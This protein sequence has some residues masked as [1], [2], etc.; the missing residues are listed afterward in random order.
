[1]ASATLHV[2]HFVR[3]PWD[4][5]GI[6]TYV[7]RISH[8]QLER[9]YEVSI[10]G[11]AAPHRSAQ[12]G[13]VPYI[14]IEDREALFH[15]FGKLEL[16]ILHLHQGT[17]LPPNPPPVIRTMH[18][19]SG[20]CPSGSRYLKR[21]KRPCDRSYTI[22]GCLWGRF[23]DRCGSARPQNIWHEFRHTSHEL[24]NADRVTTLTVSQFLKN[25]MARS[26][27]TVK[28]TQTLLSP[29][30]KVEGPF[31]PPSDETPP[32]FLF[33]GRLVPEKGVD[34]LLRALK[35]VSTSCHLDIAG[36]G[37]LDR[38]KKMVSDLGLE[39]RVTFHGWL[40]SS[41][42]S[43]LIRT[44]R[45]VV[46]PSVWH[47][48]AGLVTLEAAAHGRPVIAS[49]VGGIPEYAHEDF[50]HLVPPHDEIALARRIDELAQ[51]HDAAESMGQRGLHWAQT[52]FSMDAFL[53]RL[54]VHYDAVMG[55]STALNS[56]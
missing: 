10:L 30:P 47:E 23:V 13:D 6:Q 46:F 20:S 42:L 56:A 52:R 32:R 25:Q 35:H 24:K 54:D 48:P 21:Q 50:A 51:D 29:A 14:F 44:S 45:A 8:A 55:D 15:R 28:H 17:P 12:V 11:F 16:D 4:V 7:R 26:G 41:A 49:K 5:G 1:M 31:V 18:D 3:D 19:N 2:G 39:D 37:Y 36:E 22:S 34:W 53:D 40:G 38:Y 9:G 43:D 33:F 27:S